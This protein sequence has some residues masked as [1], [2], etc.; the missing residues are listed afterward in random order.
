[1]PPL[2]II[3]RGEGR[4][5]GAGKGGGNSSFGIVFGK[6]W[7]RVEKGEDK[8]VFGAGFLIEMTGCVLV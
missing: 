1:M 4:P 8:M 3:P 5:A 7:C 2:N 6:N